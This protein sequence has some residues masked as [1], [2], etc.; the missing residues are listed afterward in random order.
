MVKSVGI[1]TESTICLK[2]LWVAEAVQSKPRINELAVN[3][4]KVMRR[5]QVTH[6]NDAVGSQDIGSCDC[7]VHAAR[8]SG[9][10]GASSDKREGVGAV[11]GNGGDGLAVAECR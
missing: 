3:G 1:K 2:K 11:G 6:M 10:F 7:C 9:Q 5:T 4:R 8:A